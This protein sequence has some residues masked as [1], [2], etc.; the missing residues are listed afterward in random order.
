MKQNKKKETRSLRVELTREEVETASNDLANHLDELERL[1][2]EK[3]SVMDGFKAKISAIE[4]NI[5]VKK[6]MV[7]DKYDYRQV[8]VEICFDYLTKS[9]FTTRVDTLETI[10]TRDMTDSERQT[11]MNFD[12][13]AD[14][15]ISK[16]G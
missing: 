12:E 13:N 16:V 7:R 5:R 8:D 2:D 6:N 11:F 1:E 14:V 4:A 3:K 9:V 15:E 10:E